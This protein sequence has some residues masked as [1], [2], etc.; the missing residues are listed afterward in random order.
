MIT[1]Q[2]I[3]TRRDG[4]CVELQLL[5][6]SACGGCEL[7]QGCGTGALGRLLGLRRK[8]LT[9]QSAR[10]LRPGDRVTLGLSERALVRASLLLYGLPLC[11]ML[12]AGMLAYAWF[13]PPE[14]IVVLASAVGL[15]AGLRGARRCSAGLPPEGLNPQI[16]AVEVNPRS[17]AGS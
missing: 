9:L 13:E 6:E 5:R 1:E 3:V 7:N 11:G 12:L 14:W 17:L 16:I 8:P 2:A 15:C 4:D 10:A